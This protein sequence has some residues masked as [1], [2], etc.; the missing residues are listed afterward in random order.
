MAD[1]LIERV[2]TPLIEYG[3]AGRSLA[4]QDESGDA[5]LVAP[6]DGGVLIAVVDGLGHG[7]EAAV[8]ARMAMRV[9]AEH[10]AETPILLLRR[11]HEALRRTRGAALVLASVREREETVT[12]LGIGN[13]EAVLIHVGPAATRESA[14]LRSGVVGFKLPSL[15]ASAVRLARGDTLVFATDGIESRF[16]ESLGPLDLPQLVAD[17]VLEQHGKPGDDA[18]VLVARCRGLKT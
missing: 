12:W 6:F 8:A 15:R 2:R 18:L 16:A 17:R 1:A 5:Y 7:P 11:C 10:A 4:G 14:V 13:V 9:C 3:V